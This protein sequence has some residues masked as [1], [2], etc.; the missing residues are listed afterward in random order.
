M[1]R[2]ISEGALIK[3]INR[4]LKPEYKQ[5]RTARGF[6]MEQNYGHF[7]VLDLYRNMVDC[8]DV[9]LQEL[10]RELEVLAPWEEL[11]NA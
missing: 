1:E 9:D 11:A 4:K 6:N 7:Y 10:G 2:Q 3:R 8:G 5:V